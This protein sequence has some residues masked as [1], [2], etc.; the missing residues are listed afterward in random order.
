MTIVEFMHSVTQ[1]SRSVQCLSALYFA[2]RYENRPAITIEELRILLRKGRI[3]NAAKLNLADILGKSA[4][5]VDA[6]GKAG[7]KFLWSLTKT[8]EKQVRDIHGLPEA[9]VEIENDITSL[10]RLA[11]SLEDK[12]ISDY[13]SESVSCLGINALRASVV[14]LWAGAVKCIRDLIMSKGVVGV[15]ASA[16]KYDKNARRIKTVDDLEYLKESTL[17]L[18]AQDLGIYDKNEKGILSD[19]LELRNKCGH[20]G[21]YTVGPKKVSAFIEDVVGVVF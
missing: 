13:V 6:T 2:Q 12:D 1:K 17:L 16:L 19:A 15:N 21:K 8:G 9:D 4:P 10:Q 14:F 5:N 7:C 18:V 11:I 20:P 3:K